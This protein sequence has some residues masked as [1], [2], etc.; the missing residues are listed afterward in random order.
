MALL[1]KPVCDHSNHYYFIMYVFVFTV[2][3]GAANGA[4]ITDR[5]STLCS[6]MRLH[7]REPAQF[8]LAFQ[9]ITNHLLL[10]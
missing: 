5:S 9:T 4:Q 7:F 10:L 6:N 1:V 3:F 8:R 2:V